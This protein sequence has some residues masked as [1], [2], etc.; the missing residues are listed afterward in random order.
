VKKRAL[1]AML[2]LL[3][4]VPSVSIGAAKEPM[5]E[6]VAQRL[7]DL[8]SSIQ[9]LESSGKLVRIKSEV[10]PKFELAG[11]AKKYEGDKCIL[12]ERVKGSEYPVVIGLLWNRDS[13]GDLFG[14]PKE[15]VPFVIAGSIGPW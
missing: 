3:I 4:A 2:C 9:F 1:L 6:E 12:F 8:G 11:I 10:D 14:V 15:Q 5:A 13:I 7:V